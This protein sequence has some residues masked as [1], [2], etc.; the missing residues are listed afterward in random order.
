M[1]QRLKDFLLVNNSTRQKVLKNTFWLFFGQIGARFVK[2]GIIIYAARVLG[3]DGWGAFSYALGIAAFFSIFIDFGVNGVLTREGSRDPQAQERYFSTAL[4]IKVFLFVFSSIFIFV[5]FPLLISKNEIAILMPFVVLIVGFDGL[6]DFASSM[7][8]AWERMEIEAAMNILTNAFILIAGFTA[9]YFSTT[10][11]S[12][13]IGYAIGVGLG[14]IAS[15]WPVRGYLKNVWQSFSVKLI[16]PILSASWPFA[17]S[18]LMGAILLNTDTVL[19]GWFLDIAS[20]G[21]YSAAQRIALLIYIVPGLT[22][23]AFFPSMAKFFEDEARRKVL[24]EKLA[25]LQVMVALPL[26]IGGYLLAGPIILLLYGQE[27]L[28][29]VASFQIMSLT[30]LPVFLQT[31]FSNVIFSINEE[32]KLFFSSLVGVTGNLIL[33]ILLIPRWGIAGAAMAT[34]INQT[35]VMGFLWWLLRKKITFSLFRWLKKIL[36]SSGILL[37]SLLLLIYLSIN[38]Y[39][40]IL[41]G[42]LIY[43]GTLVLLKEEMVFETLQTLQNRE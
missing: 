42:G 13:S 25:T 11:K 37:L 19:I 9:L 22:A 43:I 6:R 21:Y 39:L 32:K 3:A 36:L 20:V 14:M 35:I 4:A 7:S 17:I 33:D 5:F 28:P 31:I 2:L 41:L 18:G 1:I 29:A 8:R 12:L 15:F 10:A 38:I 30:F 34:V 26:T 24:L 16:Y 23:V 40:T 27:Y